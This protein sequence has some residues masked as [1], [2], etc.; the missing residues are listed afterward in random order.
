M[1]I[2]VIVD[3]ELGG[4]LFPDNKMGRLSKA[5]DMNMMPEEDDELVEDNGAFVDVCVGISQWQSPDGRYLLEEDFKVSGEI[6]RVHKSDADPFPS[7]PHAHCV[8]GTK[9]FVGCTLHLG[10]GELFREHQSL[11]KRLESTQFLRLIDLIRSKFPGVE[12]PLK[13]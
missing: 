3:T 9:R 7:V 12:L 5:G 1:T 8:G 6:W 13:R 4:K 10:T 11:G 2:G